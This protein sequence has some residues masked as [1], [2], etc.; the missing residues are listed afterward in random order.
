MI[1]LN[2]QSKTMKSTVGGIIRTVVVADSL[3]I[4]PDPAPIILI[5]ALLNP[6]PHLEIAGRWPGQESRPRDH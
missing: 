1:T 4:I 5:S 3:V 2:R 6:I